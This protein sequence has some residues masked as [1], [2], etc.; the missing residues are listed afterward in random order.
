MSH[1]LSLHAVTYTPAA[2]LTVSTANHGVAVA[3]AVLQTTQVS[4]GRYRVFFLATV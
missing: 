2:H 3:A 4:N 1:L